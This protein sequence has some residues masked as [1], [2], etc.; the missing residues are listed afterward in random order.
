MACL[1][2]GSCCV[3]LCGKEEVDFHR[4]GCE[5][6]HLVRLIHVALVGKEVSPMHVQ[7]G[8]LSRSRQSIDCPYIAPRCLFPAMASMVCIRDLSSSWAESSSRM[9]IHSV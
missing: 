3:V 7:G 8:F 5:V 2:D 9:G 4:F 1:V 6:L